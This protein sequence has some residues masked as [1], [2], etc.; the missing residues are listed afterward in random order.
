MS[1]SRN[2]SLYFDIQDTLEKKLS[3]Y[4]IPSDVLQ[5]ALNDLF[6]SVAIHVWSRDDVRHVAER[7]DKKLSPSDIDEIL[8]TVE[9]HVDCDFGIT[10]QSIEIAV[11][12][13]YVAEEDDE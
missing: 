2:S 5:E 4:D 10:W 13:F 1:I 12:D 6:D 8:S 3:T 11:D 7:Q 9:R